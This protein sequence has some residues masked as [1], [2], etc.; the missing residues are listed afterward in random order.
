MDLGENVFVSM[1]NEEVRM[2]CRPEVDG[3]AGAPV[4][5]TSEVAM[6]END[7]SQTPCQWLDQPGAAVDASRS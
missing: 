7:S 2:P 3:T 5:P 1:I 6:L 4:E